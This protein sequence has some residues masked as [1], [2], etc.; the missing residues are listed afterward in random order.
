[1]KFDM[2]R[3]WDDARAMLAGNRQMI[4]VIAG[5]FFFLPYF[6]LMLL[7]P[8]MGETPSLAP[9][10][11]PDAALA[12]MTA[13]YRDIW[14]LVLLV[15]VLQGVGMLALYALL[16]HRD[17]PTVGQA[18]GFGFRGLLPYVGAAILQS[19]LFIFGLAIPL[20]LAGA[21]GLPA[22]VALAV[23]LAVVGAIYLYTRLSL[24][25]PVI[26]LEKQF[27]PFKA[28][29]RSW[30]LTKGNT[31]RLFLFYFLLFLVFLVVSLVI[32]MVFG[33]VFGLMGSGVALIGNGFV[34]AAVNTA[35]VCLFLA[36]LAA[37]YEQLSAGRSTATGAAEH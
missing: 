34:S 32:G 7:I 13:A 35:F 1:M 6:A 18:I 29:A 3:A 17:R 8:D 26:G 23:M 30:Q 36:V 2:T 10:A 28:I 25:T 14:W 5:I 21:T 37:A 20:G 24:T 15:A 12:A 33:V 19:L 31:L 9:G 22:V 11:D 27:N 4:L 16:R